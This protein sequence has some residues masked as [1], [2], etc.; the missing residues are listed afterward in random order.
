MP[1]GG[2]QSQQILDELLPVAEQSGI[3]PLTLL[4]WEQKLGNWGAIVNS[5]SDIAIEELDPYV[6]HLLY[7]LFLSVDEKYARYDEKPCCVLFR[8]MIEQMWP[9]LMK[10]PI[11]PPYGAK[12]R[13]SSFLAD[14]GVMAPLRALKYQWSD[15]RYLLWSRR[16][17]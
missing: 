9:E 12:D 4:F 13:L 5:E 3:N 14:G 16:L 8:K 11:N 6:S 2:C 17:S 7:E 10:W 1:L 15:L